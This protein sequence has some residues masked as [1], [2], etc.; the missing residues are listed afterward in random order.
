M[1]PQGTKR[2]EIKTPTQQAED[3]IMNMLA[4]KEENAKL[5]RILNERKLMLMLQ[6]LM[7]V[8]TVLSFIIVLVAVNVI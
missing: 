3:N 7:F 5:R 4:L 1:Y 6:I 8:N 2:K